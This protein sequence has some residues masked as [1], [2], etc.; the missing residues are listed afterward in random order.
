M[1]T[2]RGG[3]RSNDGS[4]KSV[5]TSSYNALTVKANDT[6]ERML[7]ILVSDASRHDVSVYIQE[8]SDL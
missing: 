1:R 3:L 2:Y 7:R 5:T 4:P 6:V 8:E